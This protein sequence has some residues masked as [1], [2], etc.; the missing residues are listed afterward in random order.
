[1][2]LVANGMDQTRSLCP[3]IKLRWNGGI[4]GIRSIAQSGIK[5]FRDVGERC[6]HEDAGIVEGHV[7]EVLIMASSPGGVLDGVVRVNEVVSIDLSFHQ[8]LGSRQRQVPVVRW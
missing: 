5:V 1:M 7:L 3:G 2:L 8:R 4:A 6:A